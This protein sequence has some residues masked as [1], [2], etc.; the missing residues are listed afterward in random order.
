MQNPLILRLAPALLAKLKD[1][2]LI[3]KS[4]SKVELFQLSLYLCSKPSHDRS[5]TDLK[6]LAKLT[7]NIQF[8]KNI[9][10]QNGP[11]TLQQCLKALTLEQHD[12]DHTVFHKGSYG[13]KFYII[14]KGLVGVYVTNPKQFRGSVV[15]NHSPALPRKPTAMLKVNEMGQGDSFGELALINDAPRMATILTHTPCIFAVLNKK[16]FK[17]IFQQ[18]QQ[19]KLLNEISLLEKVSGFENISRRGL[20]MFVYTFPIKKYQY[21]EYI[22][23]END[24]CDDTFYIIRSG[25]FRV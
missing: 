21:R 18:I 8:F 20:N 7:D 22:F 19:Q 11:H 12:Q 1:P 24:P 10:E 4:L 3:L 14:L 15:L 5:M 23:K 25:T 2:S 16:D 9:Q 6:I 13:T 17:N